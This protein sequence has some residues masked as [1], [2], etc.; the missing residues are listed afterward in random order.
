MDRDPEGGRADGIQRR[1][2]LN[3]AL[4]AA[5][6]LAVGAFSP[7]RAFAHSN[8]GLNTGDGGIGLDPRA[9]RG[10]NLPSTFNVG[11]WMRDERLTFQSRR[12]KL[13]R[14]SY[15]AS[16]RGHASPIIERRPSP[17]RP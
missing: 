4:L 5:G 14:A 7:M 13:A 9:S 16:A 10:G 11:H 8:V 1:D 6:G 17:S 3:G 12:V 15:V 2:F